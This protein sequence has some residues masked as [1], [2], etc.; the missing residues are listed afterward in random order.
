M[1]NLSIADLAELAAQTEDQS[2][3]K[4][5]GD[6]EYTIA[7]AGVGVARFVEYIELGMAKQKPYQGKPKADA[8]MV[9]LTFELLSAKNIREIEVDG[10]KRTVA[11]RITLTLNKNQGEKAKFKKLFDKMVYGR[12][13]IR[14]YTQMLGQAFLVTITHNADAKD[15]KKIYANLNDK[16]GNYLIGAPRMQTQEADALAGTDAVYADISSRVPANITPLRIFLWDHPNKACWDSLFI[17]GERDVK[18]DKGEVTGKESKNWLQERIKAATNYA[19]SPLQALL[20]GVADLPTTEAEAAAVEKPAPAAQS[21][22]AETA[23]PSDAA[24]Q[25]LASSKP[26]ATTATDDLAAL[27]L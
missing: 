16:D 15:P 2:E 27:G 12:E 18:N 17:D 11:D 25:E 26:A 23:S 1:S 8:E 9:R 24:L 19:G 3:T 7:P 20:A 6:F 21:G 5:G 22:A 10:V 14:H 4:S 13:G